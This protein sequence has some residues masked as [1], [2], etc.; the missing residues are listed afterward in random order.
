M[1]NEKK[2][3]VSY[4][5]ISLDTKYMNKSNYSIIT[6]KKKR[7]RLY[8]E[9]QKI[10]KKTNLIRVK[11]LIIIKHIKFLWK[12]R[13]RYYKLLVYNYRNKKSK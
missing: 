6:I 10:L 5:N 13:T 9:M 7:R 12:I 3:Y 2:F 1:S 11:S 8:Y 4:H